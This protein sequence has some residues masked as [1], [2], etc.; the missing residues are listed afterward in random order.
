M[1]FMT[2]KICS[3]HKAVDRPESKWFYHSFVSYRIFWI[4][5]VKQLIH[6]CMG[7]AYSRN[8]A[9]VAHHDNGVS[10]LI[11]YTTTQLN[12]L[13]D[14]VWNSGRTRVRKK[15]RKYWL[16]IYIREIFRPFIYFEFNSSNWNFWV[17]LFP[18][19]ESK[20][21]T[22][23]DNI[24]LLSLWWWFILWKWAEF[25]FTHHGIVALVHCRK[26]NNKYANL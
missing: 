22:H 13:L 16:K 8:I 20:R 21:Q 23:I 3:H 4:I 2:S 25:A 9:Q 1:I 11:V 7:F 15:E 12:V 24:W 14:H 19:F 6:F 18:N 5:R 26:W 17:K 10:L